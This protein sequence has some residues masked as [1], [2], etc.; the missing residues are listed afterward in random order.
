MERDLRAG[1]RPQHAH[2]CMGYR[3]APPLPVAKDNGN[4]AIQAINK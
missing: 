1:I 4:F 2:H 3:F